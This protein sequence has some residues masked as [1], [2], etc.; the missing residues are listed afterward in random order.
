MASGRSTSAVPVSQAIVTNSHRGDAGV[1][2]GAGAAEPR[3]APVRAWFGATWVTSPAMPLEEVDVAGAGSESVM[4]M[5]ATSIDAT[6][7]TAATTNVA[8]RRR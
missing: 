1:D 5:D 4:S 6:G 7:T 2:T 8:A 3:P